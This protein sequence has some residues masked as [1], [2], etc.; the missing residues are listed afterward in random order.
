M[1]AEDKKIELEIGHVLFVD[2]VGYSKLLINEQGELLEHLKAGKWGSGW[3]QGV[4][5]G[6]NLDSSGAHRRT[7]A[8]RDF[9]SACHLNARLAHTYESVRQG[10]DAIRIDE[11]IKALVPGDDCPDGAIAR[12]K[13]RL[14][15]L[16]EPLRE[17]VSGDLKGVPPD[18]V[19][20]E[21]Y[22]LA[23][24]ERDYPA[25]ERLLRDLSAEFEWP[26]LAFGHTRSVNEAL[27]AVARGAEAGTVESALV[28][29][30][31][32]TEKLLAAHP[33]NFQLHGE[34]G[35][36]DALRGRKEDAIREGRRWFEL[37]KTPTLEKNAAEA[38]LALIYARVGEPDKAIELIEKLL[39]LPSILSTMWDS[40]MTQADLKWR[41]VWDP[42]RS[43]P[44]FQ[45]T[46][47]GPEPKTVY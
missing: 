18:E 45:K 6:A 36:I 40:C 41:W 21:R 26:E 2:I 11:R 19:A 47:E 30:R 37:E 31:A 24:L 9:G 7:A 46:L 3:G 10:Q 23:V 22:Q 5:Q 25:A 28:A 38:N 39:T 34:L 44:R 17:F 15:G 27:L 1:A 4:G 14:S 12:A 35:L 33:E 32:E 13:F 42:L 20:L 43:D 16:L 8:R 29:A